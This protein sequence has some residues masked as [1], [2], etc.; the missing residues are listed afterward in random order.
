ME[1]LFK[2]GDKVFDIRVGW[3]T[4]KYVYSTDWEKAE[5]EFLVCE[6]DF[7][8]GEEPYIY[9]KKSAQMLSFTEYTLQGFSQERPIDYND[10]VGKWGKFW[11][12]DLEGV[13]IGKLLYYHDNP[14]NNYRFRNSYGFFQFFEPLTEE[15]I[16]ILNL[17]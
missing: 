12:E 3:G 11:D 6:V 9:T 15:Q 13:N 2:I 4:V 1:T 10:Y 14:A 17:E 7:N 8:N 16:K 5:P